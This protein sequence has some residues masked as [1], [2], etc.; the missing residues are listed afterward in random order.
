VFGAVKAVIKNPTE[1]G[2]SNADGAVFP[3]ALEGVLPA[4]G[5]TVADG[6]PVLTWTALNGIGNPSEIG[7]LYFLYDKNPWDPSAK[8]IWGNSP[9][10]TGDLATT[11]PSS[12][13]A[14]KTGTYYWWVSG[15][16]F[17]ALKKADSFSFTAPRKI[18]VP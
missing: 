5:A 15:V 2:F 17:D 6:R 13:P 1:S 3:R 16:S 11:Y 12:L 14:L 4:D 18:V 8:L 10:A 9:K 7:Y